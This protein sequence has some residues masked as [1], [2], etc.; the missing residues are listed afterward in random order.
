MMLTHDSSTSQCGSGCAKSTAAFKC[1]TDWDC[2]L[3][4]ACKGDGTCACDAWASG[5]DWCVAKI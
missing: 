3:A 1:R 4:G 5:A 2:S